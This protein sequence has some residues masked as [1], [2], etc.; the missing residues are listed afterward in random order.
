MKRPG[1]PRVAWLRRETARRPPPTVAGRNGATGRSRSA[2]L[3]R[4]G[5]RI[6]RSGP[7]SPGRRPG[8]CPLMRWDWRTGN[9]LGDVEGVAE[10]MPGGT[11]VASVPSRICTCPAATELAAA[12][13]TPLK[14]PPPCDLGT[15]FP[16]AGFRIDAACPKYPFRDEVGCGFSSFPSPRAGLTCRCWRFLTG[17][18][19]RLSHRSVIF[20]G[21]PPG[22]APRRHMELPDVARAGQ[23]TARRRV[24]ALAGVLC[25]GFGLRGT[26]RDLGVAW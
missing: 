8:R 4:R 5:C 14:Y 25:T 13:V 26:E 10:P 24:P 21:G 7:R 22:R 6:W 1:P 12:A 15:R 20:L 11:E 18:S 3:R 17:P 19:A 9:W 2:P 16:P 23:W